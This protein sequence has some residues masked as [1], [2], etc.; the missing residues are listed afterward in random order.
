MLEINPG[1]ILWTIVT[2]IILLVVLRAVAWKPLLGALTAREEKIRTSLQRTEQAQQEAEKLLEE[3]KHQLAQAEE[4]SQR[5][6][7][8]GRETGERLKAE[9]I[10]KA[11]ASSRDMI[12][13]AKEEIRREKDAALIELRGEVADLAIMA[14][15]KVLD[16]N[17]DAPKQ[18]EL[19]ETAIREINKR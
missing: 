14:A 18:R 16:A 15:E 8:E 13:Q 19:V 17:L 5:A 9:I 10:E 4:Q 3:N 6:I 7:K 2:F 1:L 12:E 11:N